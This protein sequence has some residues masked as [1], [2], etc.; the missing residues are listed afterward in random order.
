MNPSINTLSV[1]DLNAPTRGHRV[2]E[3]VR[4]QEP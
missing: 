2:A 1:N 3:W 4:K